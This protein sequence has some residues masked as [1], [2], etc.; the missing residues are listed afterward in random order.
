MTRMKLLPLAVALTLCAVVAAGARDQP[1][2]KVREAVDK[3]RPQ[4]AIRALDPI[5][6]AALKEGAHA[7]ATRAIVQRITLESPN[8]EDRI[9]RLQADI[10]RAPEPMRPV[11]EVIL[12][13]W[14]RSYLGDRREMFGSRSPTATSPGRDVASWDPSRMSAEVDVLLRRALAADGLKRTPIAAYDALL[15]RRSMP[16]AYRPTLY[17]FVA[18]EALEFYTSGQNAD[19]GEDP[20]EMD[21]AGPIF[22]AA[23][24]FARWQVATSDT[25]SPAFRAIRLYQELLRFHA[26]DAD[27]SARIDVDLARL[28][29]G[30]NRAFGPEK[31]TRY[32]AAL[33]ALARRY[34]DHELS[35]RALAWQATELQ[36]PGD[37]S[38][39]WNI[40]RRGA[41]RFPESVGGR[42]CANV[43]REIEEKSLSI[44]TERVWNGSTSAIEVR[45][46]NLDRVCFRIVPFDFEAAVRAGRD[47]DDRPNAQRLKE[48]VAGEPVRAWS[49]N[50]PPTPDFRE[51]RVSLPTP[52]GLAPGSYYLIAS[53][54]SD[55]NNVVHGTT[56]W[57]S[58]LALVVR[59]GKRGGVEGFVLDAATGAPVVGSEVRTWI[60]GYRGAR[61][62]ATAT[63]TDGDGRFHTPG[64][65][66][67]YVVLASHAGQRL[68][69]TDE[70]WSFSSRESAP[71]ARTVLFTDRALYRPGQT[72][73]YKGLCTR[74]DPTNDRYDVLPDT[75]VTVVFSDV[76]RVEIARQQHR[77]ND[78]GS[79]SGSFTVPGARLP[80]LLVIRVETGPA[81]EAHVRFEEYKRPRFAVSL[82]APALAPRLGG[83]V[84]LRGT[85]TAYTGAAVDGARVRWRVVRQAHHPPWW[86]WRVGPDA[87]AG[88]EHE[89]ARG[90]ATTGV[91]G[92]FR[93]TFTARPD[94]EASEAGEPLFLY[95]VH[96]D[97]TD[98][99]G[100]T[101]SADRAVPVGYTALVALLAAEE[102]QVVT[103]PVE[104][105]VRTASPDGV[106]VASACTLRID[107]LRQPIRVDR[108]GLSDR[109]EGDERRSSVLATPDSTLGPDPA[110][111]PAEQEVF[112]RAVRTDTTGL[113]KVTARLGAGAYRVRLE[114]R[115]RFGRRATAALP[116]RVLDPRAS[117]FPLQVPD[118]LAA[119]AWTIEPGTEFV[120]LWGSGYQGARAY[121]EIEHRGETLQAYWTAPGE[122]QAMIRQPVTEAM[123]GGFTVRVTMV[124]ENRAH[125]HERIVNVPWTSQRLAMRWEHFVSKLD[126]GR[127]ETWTAVIAGPDATAAAAEMVAVLY[128]ASLDA[129][130]PHAW[131][132]AWEFRREDPSRPARCENGSVSLRRFAGNWPYPWQPVNVN[133]RGLVPIW[134]PSRGRAA[135]RTSH[136]ISAHSIRGGRP[137]EQ[138]FQ[139][140]GVSVA[141]P[142]MAYAPILGPGGRAATSGP[143]PG[144]TVLRRNLEETAFFFPHLVADAKGQVKMTFI[145][146]EALTEWRFLGFAHDRRLRHGM[147]EARAITTRDLMVQPNPPR[148]LREGDTLE[149]TVKVTNRSNRRQSGRV[150]LTLADAA[151]HESA[152][153]AL[154][155]RVPEQRF[156]VPARESRVHAWRLAVSTGTGM[157][158]YRAVASTG[159]QSDGEEGLLPVLPRAVLV[160]ESLPLSIRG[161]QTRS[162][163]FARL[164]LSGGSA[165][166]RHQSLTVQMASH[167]TW[168]AVL[169]LPY[170]MEL[171][172]E[173]VEQTFNRLYANAL[174]RHIAASDP[175]IDQVFEQW[176][177]TPALNSPLENNREVAAVGLEETPWLR[178][179]S[180]E[181]Q[182]RRNVG[183]L[184]DRNRLEAETAALVRQLSA[185]QL[186]DGAWPWFPGGRRDDYI[187]LYITAGFG[188]MRHLG[189]SVDLGS[190][191]R[192]LDGLDA[193]AER[194]HRAAVD[195]R[196]RDGSPLTPA[197][198]LYL[199]GRSF[200]MKDRPAAPGARRVIDYWLWQ[201]RRHWPRLGRQSQAQLALALA[202]FGDHRTARDIVRSLRERA[203]RDEE[204]GMFWREDEA[205]WW[206]HRAPIETQAVVIEAFQ[207]VAGNAAAVEDC[208]LW[209]LRQKQTQDWRTSKATA[210]AVY[211]LLLRGANLL[212]SSRPVEVSLGGQV[213]TPDAI[214]AG[215]GFY[216]K[217]FVR[218]EVTPNMASVAMR[219]T[220]P[221]PAWGSIHWQYL[222]DVS[223]VRDWQGTPLTVRK[224][225]WTREADT[226][227]PVLVP[228]TGP[229]RVGEEIVVRLEMRVDRDVEYVHVMDQRG[230]GVEPTQVLSGYRYRDGLRYYESTRDAA[231]HFFIDY[232][233]RGTHVLEYA[234]RVQ[235]RGRFETG[236]AQIQ[237]MY[238]PEFSG[239]SE[240]VLL[241]AR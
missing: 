127:R 222:E 66:G 88:R 185:A 122:N 16:D 210:D 8:L 94:P 132:G 115:D 10:V 144:R 216:E 46:R 200:Y 17:D 165:T 69:S 230:S 118:L 219:G 221:G 170:L 217:R 62:E 237:C 159:Q 229:V 235:H 161:A 3:G 218:E 151:T 68:G 110:R 22:A 231:S 223:K 194:K 79:F 2:R 106:P 82:E 78:Y 173:C 145:M 89:I 34:P 177:T 172:R 143:D 93:V 44:T 14:I 152:D 123:R 83:E 181:S 126:P 42:E 6:A 129:F 190:A 56:F 182:A 95:S 220:D 25:A 240:S 26:E 48:M 71:T 176:R 84:T 108:V 155:N 149:L 7:E 112:A 179:A 187:T 53:D 197:V 47:M 50:V 97:V 125:L 109:Y 232:L 99:A 137:G 134:E 13:R 107:R 205:S 31:T 19:R 204:L 241:D 175:R 40:A 73:R 35:A 30:R 207:E 23:E 178:Q 180:S 148:F 183:I 92:A 166:L 186:P 211:A 9:D 163:D 52:L 64:P 169:A 51:R 105:R 63:A 80:G 133:Y 72:V 60:G 140:D 103:E 65:E 199:Y 21:A 193:W 77:T 117:R 11:M 39:A 120:A 188:R 142:S 86:K 116:L 160:T 55:F 67:I 100:E 212:G 36:Q 214:Q 184:F 27:P 138:L 102:W 167:P 74:S 76:H 85:A 41:G 130:G 81:G 195:Q 168:Y 171:P 215:T 128:D 12:A 153:A 59:S 75:A 236:T 57:V 119:P 174:A 114:T 239:H 238:A 104:I 157:L 147:I 136:W 213:V 4:T 224:T 18:G 233:P 124:H 208:K 189:V 5:L 96:A 20:V 87:L 154:D 49:V 203:V 33:D 156:D 32:L 98:P 113:A 198:A 139:F 58:T 196:A 206:W 150:S 38:V 45:Y 226:R 209:L 43:I 158:T 135:S 146:P 111:W 61:S 54:T 90:S 225:L 228:L 101:R 131:P 15:E 29:F 1:W 24:E 192:A 162:V 227:G 121:V 202:R 28:R 70:T 91:D 201:T 141:D 234:A 37:R 164:R 191:L